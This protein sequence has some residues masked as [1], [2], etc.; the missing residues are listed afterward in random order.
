MVSEISI[1]EASRRLDKQLRPQPWYVSVGVGETDE[2]EVI[3]LY[4]KTKGHRELTKL[5]KRWMSFRLIVEAVGSIR[6]VQHQ[7]AHRA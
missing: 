7:H 4:V 6:P 1:E 3:F 5:G 2:G